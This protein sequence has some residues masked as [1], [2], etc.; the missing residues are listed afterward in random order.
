MGREYL[1]TME[2]GCRL[3][4]LILYHRSLLNYKAKICFEIDAS[5]VS[6]ESLTIDGNIFG[7][8][9]K[10]VSILIQ[11]HAIINRLNCNYIL[12]YSNKSL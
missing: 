8:R 6:F 7:Y 1:E 10:V 2:H 9:S 12:A 5:F 4:M 3:W 11:I